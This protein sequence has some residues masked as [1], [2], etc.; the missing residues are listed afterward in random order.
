MLQGKYGVGRVIARPFAGTAGSFYR[1][2]RRHDFSLPPPF[3]MLQ[4]LSQAGKKTV[5]I[6]KIYDIF[7]G[8]GIHETYATASNRE[9]IARTCEVLRKGG[10]DFLFINMLDFDQN[11][12]HRNDVHGFARALEEF[13]KTLPDILQ[14]MR[15][16]DLLVI[17]ADHGCDPTQLHSTDHS[18]EYVPLLVFSRGGALGKSL[19]LRESFADVGKTLADFFDL[20]AINLPG[21]SFF[22]LP[23]GQ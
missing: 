5:G 4:V 2:S 18:R 12:G 8:A 15:P 3:N 1:T 19:G 6:G 21:T 9:G 16:G 23:R 13:D 10:F 14:E 20:E 17:T 22:P 11:Y 7:T